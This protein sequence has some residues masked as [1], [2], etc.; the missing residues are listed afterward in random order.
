MSLFKKLFMIAV[1]I[2]L[3]SGIYGCKKEGP[4]ERAGKNL[5]N[6]MEDAK[7]KLDDATK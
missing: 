4:A 1:I 5:D 2:L 6:A 3:V 7:E